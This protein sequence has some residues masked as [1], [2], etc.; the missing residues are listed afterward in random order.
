MAGRICRVDDWWIGCREEA[1]EDSEE[2]GED[3]EQ[4][5]EDSGQDN[6]SN[7]RCFIDPVYDQTEIQVFE[8]IKYGSA[9]NHMT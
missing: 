9:Y 8:D 5:D 3:T 6:D 7:L 1:D 4:E 2:E